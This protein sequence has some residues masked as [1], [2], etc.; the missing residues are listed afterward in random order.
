MPRKRY[1]REVQTTPR[2]GDAAQARRRLQIRQRLATAIER[3]LALGEFDDAV[4]V[5]TLTDRNTVTALID[6]LVRQLREA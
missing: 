1:T 6:D 4:G 5:A 3:M 2:G